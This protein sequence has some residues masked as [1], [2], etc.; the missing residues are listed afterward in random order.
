LKKFITKKKVK[1]AEC[2]KYE[3]DTYIKTALYYLPECLI[4]Y[5]ERN[6]EKGYIKNDIEL[7][8]TLDFEYYFCN[9]D[10]IKQSN[11]VYDLKGLIYYNLYGEDF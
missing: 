4:I 2:S 8:K 10:L 5:F 1:H 6:S 3:K 11:T 7:M 9:E